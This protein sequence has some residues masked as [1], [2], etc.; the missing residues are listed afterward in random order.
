MPWLFLF[1]RNLLTMAI[2]YY[3]DVPLKAHIK[4]YAEHHIH[5]TPE[6][7]TK[8]SAIGLLIYLA[9]DETPPDWKPSKDKSSLE[10]KVWRQLA[11]TQSRGFII[12]TKKAKLFEDMLDSMFMDELLN[13][14]IFQMKINGFNKLDSMRLFLN[15]YN[16]TERDLPLDTLKKRVYRAEKALNAPPT[17]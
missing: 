4:K 2:Q 12:T 17:L 3:V 11:P 14:I 9:L 15:K 6:Y 16:I 13:F 10:I 7:V 1:W 8:K 5:K